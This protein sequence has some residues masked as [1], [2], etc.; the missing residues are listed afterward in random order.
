MRFPMDII[1][2]MKDC[3]LSVLWPKKDIIGFLENCGC[4]AND[5]KPVVNYK[6]ENMSRAAIVEAV[7]DQLNARSDFGLGQ[8]RAMMKRL[9][10]WDHFPPFWFEK[11]AK[12]SRATADKNLNHLRQLQEIRDAEIK[13]ERDRVRAAEERRK[14][15]IVKL[16]DV[17]ADFLGLFTD[18]GLSS[19]KR[20]YA[21]ETVLRNLLLLSELETTEAFKING[22]QI[23][24]AVKYDGEHYLI[25]AKWHDAPSS[26]EPLYQFVGKVEGKMYGRGIFISI[27]GFSSNVVQSLVAGKAIKTV[28]VDGGDITLAVEGLMT[29]AEM[30][31]RKV[32]AAQTRGLIYVDAMN[33]SPK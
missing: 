11:E 20:G 10:E 17:K 23:D 33:G 21:L 14:R 31:D 25:E 18:T 12:L 32:R 26:N 29:F 9:I 4:T 27:N 30:I 7:F 28:L 16:D 2:C 24:G 1:A 8:Y 19:Q 3:I 15:P 13:K 6:M 22:E 5:M